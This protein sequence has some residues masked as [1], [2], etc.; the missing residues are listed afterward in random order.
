MYFYLYVY[1]FFYALMY[2]FIVG[3]M[4]I[5]MFICSFKV[6]CIDAFHLLIHSL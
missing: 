1:L 6:L 4:Y 2:E 5:F 3:K